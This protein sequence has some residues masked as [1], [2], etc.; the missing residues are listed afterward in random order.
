MKNFHFVARTGIPAEN[1]EEAC[2]DIASHFLDVADI[3]HTEFAYRRPLLLPMD[4]VGSMRLGPEE[5]EAV[6]D[7]DAAVAAIAYALEQC[8][9]DDDSMAFLRYWN[10]GGF[11]I[12]RSNWENIPDEVFIGAEVGFVPTQQDKPNA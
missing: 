9:G 1:L 2:L 12:L 5:P 7:N 3:D 8:E 10:A 4:H 11:D 6:E